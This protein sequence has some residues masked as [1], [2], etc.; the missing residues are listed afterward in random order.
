[1][2]DFFWVKKYL[3]N[4]RGDL[5]AHRVCLQYFFLGSKSYLLL[6]RPWGGLLDY[7]PSSNNFF[8]GWKTIFGYWGGLI[9][10]GGS[11]KNFFWVKNH[12]RDS[13]GDLLDH[14]VSP[15]IF[16]W[17]KNLFFVCWE[18]LLSAPLYNIFLFL[19]LKTIFCLL[20]D[21]AGLWVLSQKNFLS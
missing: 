14:W 19:G 2:F 12:L 13:R 16:F 17:A 3:F 6:V 20:R 18:G 11:S 9:D 4:L 8:L 7:G 1:M 5:L 15:K 10:Y 21:S